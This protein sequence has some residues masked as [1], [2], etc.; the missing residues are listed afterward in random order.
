MY[1]Q[2]NSAKNT[3]IAFRKNMHATEESDSYCEGMTDLLGAEYLVQSVLVLELG[4]WVIHRVTMVLL[5]H[6]GILCL[7][8]PVST[9]EIN[10]LKG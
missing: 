3:L 10:T 7:G 1:F 4:I 6:S 8:G 9:K 2:S 5:S